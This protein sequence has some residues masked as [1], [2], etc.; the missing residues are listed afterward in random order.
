MLL[1]EVDQHRS[2]VD[3]VTLLATRDLSSYA[4]TVLDESPVKAAGQLRAA[5]GAVI[6]TYGETAAVVGALF[7]ETARPIPGFTATLVTPTIGMDSEIGWAL[8][9]LFKPDLFDPADTVDRLA[10]VTQKFVANAD[11]ETV[12]LAGLKDPTSRGVRWYANTGA[13]AFCALMSSQAVPTTDPHWHA[14]C[15]CVQVPS[16]DGSPLPEADYMDKYSEAAYGARSYLIE[17]RN[18]H[19]DWATT[20]PRRFL[21]AHPEFSINNKNLTRVMRE[22]FG[23]TK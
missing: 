20:S 18:Q 3:A 16:W 12:R 5:A 13:C 17:A 14:N 9:P 22:R 8:D 15:R 4:A 11:R 6:T 2:D 19:P 7:Y 21:K 1:S 10:G 23:F